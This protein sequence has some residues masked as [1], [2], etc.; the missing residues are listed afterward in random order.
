[1]VDL[2]LRRILEYREFFIDEEPIDIRASLK[3]FD[4]NMLIRMAAILSLH[5]GNIQ[6]PDDQYSL[7]SRVSEKHIP[8]LKKL[9]DDY[10]DRLFNNRQHVVQISTFRTGL[11]LWRL[12]FSIRKEDYKGDVNESDIELLFFKV[13]L[14]INE[15]LVSF[16]GEAKD[17]Q[18][19]ELLFLCGYLNNDSNDYDYNVVIRT[20]Y[21]YFQQLV[22]FIPTNEVMIK[23]QKVLFDKWRIDSWQQYFVTLFLLTKETE[24]YKQQKQDGVPIISVDKLI[25]N[26]QTGFFSKTL[27]DSLSIKEDEYI[28]Y[29][30][31]NDKECNV[32][33]RRFRAKP[34]VK[35]NTGGYVVINNQF[36]CERL[37]NSLYFDFMPL[38]NGRKDSVG[39]F[40]F[41][42][43][44]TEKVLFRNI[45]FGC[46]P[47]DFYTFPSREDVIKKEKSHEPDFYVRTR[48]GELILVE[49]KA[50][51][52][53][54]ICRDRG[55]YRR[56][57]DELHE[58]IILK[59]RNLDSRRTPYNGNPMPI[60][61]GQLIHHID[62][63]EAYT[64]QWD[65]AIPDQVVYYPVLVFEDVRFF[66]PGLLSLINRWFYEEIKKCDELNLLEIECM[67]VMV[68]SINTIYLYGDYI[69]CNGLT[70]LIDRFLNEVAVYDKTTG[71]Y[72]FKTVCECFDGYLRRNH[73]DK[74]KETAKMVERFLKQ[75][76]CNAKCIDK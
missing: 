25:E 50:I 75:V 70:Q 54:G 68:L 76:N 13:I 48:K 12:I 32:D 41:N 3:M 69:R 39:F 74:S 23:A 47:K 60:G 10:F 24:D 35:L 20:Q 15:T 26:D 33:Y 45:F 67:P 73:F 57:L 72:L 16:R 71:Q 63:I 29:E 5:Y 8:R 1:M 2:E 38:I 59:T 56:L 65:D 53:N 58:K 42:K 49:C 31:D 9:F 30:N 7:F 62:S 28:S 11:E 64:F 34:F 4:R 43:D 55:D 21:Y 40:D 44:F 17:F 46:I 6:T 14:T 66:R 22:D 18:K 36:L 19:D 27:I 51:K 61:I 37:Y 52:M